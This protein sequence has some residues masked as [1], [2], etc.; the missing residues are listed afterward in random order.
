MKLILTFAV[1]LMTTLYASGAIE[2][3]NYFK[4]AHKRR[5]KPCEGPYGQIAHGKKIKMYNVL[6]A[7]AP[8]KCKS[9][10]RVCTNGEIT[11]SYIFPGCTEV[12]ATV[13]H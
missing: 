10:I 11:G 4:P 5:Q 6:V 1:T 2:E 3:E 8:E 7:Q 9:E 12:P 13:R